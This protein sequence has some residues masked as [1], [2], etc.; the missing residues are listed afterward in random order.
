M[1]LSLIHPEH[2]WNCLHNRGYRASF[3]TCF[4]TWIKLGKGARSP[5]N[6]PV[7]FGNT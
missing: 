2:L 5:T 4:R 6:P 3:R 1:T 7:L